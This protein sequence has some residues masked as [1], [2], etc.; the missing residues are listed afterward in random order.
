MGPGAM[1]WDTSYK[2]AVMRV[3]KA[4][5]PALDLSELD[6]PSGIWVA[7]VVLAVGVAAWL[8]LKSSPRV[9]SAAVAVHELPRFKLWMP[10]GA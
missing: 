10:R 7:A 3:G 4:E 8:W 9:G 1:S 6:L 2:V 5:D